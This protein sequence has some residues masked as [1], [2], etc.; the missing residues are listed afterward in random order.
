M[1]RVWS[2]DGLWD[3]YAMSQYGNIT[4]ISESPI[5]EG[6]LYVGTDDGLIQVS[7]DGGSN[8]R[9]VDKIF[10]VPEGFFVNDIKADLHD[11]DTVYAVMDD[12]KTGD[13][14]PYV[15][16]STDRGRTRAPICQNGHSSGGSF[17]IMLC[18]N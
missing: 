12:H 9:S 1:D 14:D 16:R 13:Y 8:W 17:K 4:S 11:P 7:E 10:G 6:L 18:P 2:I 15:V 3:L 5:V